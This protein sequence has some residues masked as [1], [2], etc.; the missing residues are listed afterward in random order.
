MIRR[1]WN[2]AHVPSATMRL[3]SQYLP[4]ESTPVSG[5]TDDE[6]S[7][8]TIAYYLQSIGGPRGLAQLY[9][10]AGLLHLEGAAATLLAASYST[11]SSIRIPIQS[12]IGEGGTEAWKR[13]REAAAK[14]FERA[15]TI[16]PGLDIPAIPVEEAMELE[17]PTLILASS[18]P[19]SVRSKESQYEDSETEI[20]MVRRRRKK[21][22]QVVLEK[23]N[24]DLEDTDN[25][26][27]LYIPGLIGA[28][29]ALLVFG[30]VGALSFSW[31][32]RS[33]SS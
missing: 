20:P 16:A 18:A 9:L 5:E 12:Q 28:G 13:D 23:T 17:M 19:D 11:L 29:T 27:Y 2:Q 1:A 6:P 26:W 30:I 10:E 21:E 8:G 32:R 25:T 31:S 33:Q 4:L 14:F 3:V 24:G 22:E 15:R 7:P